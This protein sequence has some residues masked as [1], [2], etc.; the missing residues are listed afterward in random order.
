VGELH[1]EIRAIGYVPDTR[2]MLHDIEEG[3]KERA[4]MNRSERLAIAFELVSMPPGTP[5]RVMKNLRIC[6]DSGEQLIPPGAVLHH[7]QHARHA[8]HSARDSVEHLARGVE[9][10]CAA[11]RVAVAATVSSRSRVA[12]RCA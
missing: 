9:R 1:K 6:G 2:F 5:L 10:W 4:L 12:W 11:W 3:A 7:R 8:P